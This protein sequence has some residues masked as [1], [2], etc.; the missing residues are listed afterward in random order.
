MKNFLPLTLLLLFITATSHA[1]S[2]YSKA[3][4]NPSHSPVI[5]L[6]GGPGNSSVFFQANAAQALAEKG[7]Y[8]IVYDRR[9]EGRSAN[10]QAKMNF[11]E[12]LADIDSIYQQYHLK[13]ATLIGF[14][15][16][17]LITA[18]YTAAHP[19]KVSR[20]ILVSALVDQ[21]ATYN[22]IFNRC[23]DIYLKKKDTAALADLKKVQ[24]LDYNTLEYRTRI[25]QHASNNKF[26]TVPEPNE[27]ARAIRARNDTSNLIKSYVKNTSAVATFFANDSLHNFSS[28]PILS[29]IVKTG[30]PVYAIYGD[31]DM[32]FSPGQL[33][34]LKKVIGSGHLT[35]V[36]NASHTVFDDN[37][38]E[39]LAAAQGYL[40]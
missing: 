12:Y 5:F 6:H 21:Q 33:Q 15:F 9:G 19:E 23:S 8:V 36:S 32:I 38:P 35:M 20:V 34:Q 27:M 18:K 10:P 30:I 29:S 17:G 4:G 2:L 25:F 40:K 31:H 14:S 26:F 39:F 7:F 22:T 1:Q 3:Y 13:K 24:Q 11:R 37:Q 28:L 16:G